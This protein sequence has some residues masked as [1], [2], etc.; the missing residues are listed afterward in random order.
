MSSCTSH[1]FFLKQKQTTKPLFSIVN[2]FAQVERHCSYTLF[3]YC[4]LPRW[5]HLT[6]THTPET[7][8]SANELVDDL[9]RQCLTT[10]MGGDTT[11]KVRLFSNPIHANDLL[12]SVSFVKLAPMAYRLAHIYRALN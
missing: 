4:G 2:S 6:R 10:L 9:A 1:N 5:T 12:A 8:S 7:S 11:L 3:R